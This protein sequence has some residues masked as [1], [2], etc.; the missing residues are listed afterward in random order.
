PALTLQP[1]RGIN[2][3]DGWETARKK[4][5]PAVLEVGPDGL[6]PG[7][8]WAILRLGVTGEIKC[9]MVDTNHFKKKF[10]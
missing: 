5:R 3:G 10:P 9:L 6:A 4:D 8:D 1:G 7:G 2:M